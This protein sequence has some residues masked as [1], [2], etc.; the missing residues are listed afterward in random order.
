MFVRLFA[1]LRAVSLACMPTYLV[2]LYLPGQ[3]RAWLEEQLARLPSEGGVRYLGSIYIPG[4]ESCFCRFEAAD[5]TSVREANLQAGIPPGRI[6]DFTEL[7]SLKR[8]HQ[9]GEHR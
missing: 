1:L 6:V 4:D 7:P 5:A 2:E 3:D 9:Q 8:S